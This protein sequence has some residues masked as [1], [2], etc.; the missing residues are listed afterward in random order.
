MAIIAWG[1]TV[2]EKQIHASVMYNNESHVHDY[3]HPHLPQCMQ[4]KLVFNFDP[5]IHTCK[6]TPS[7]HLGVWW[8]EWICSCCSVLTIIII[9][10][11]VWFSF[12]CIMHAHMYIHAVIDHAWYG[13]VICH[14]YII[15]MH[16]CHPKLKYNVWVNYNCACEQL[17]M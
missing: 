1:V 11:N 9:V 13:H 7:K 15:W 12:N 4:Y 2:V 8:P 5:Y 17:L 14:V 6:H 16:S 3:M 10:I